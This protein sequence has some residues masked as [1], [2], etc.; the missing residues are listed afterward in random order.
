V[1]KCQS[2]LEIHGW[3]KAQRLGTLTQYRACLCF[4]AVH[5]RTV[6]LAVT[7]GKHSW[8]FA[9]GPRSYSTDYDPSLWNSFPLVT[10]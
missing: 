4:Y 5:S 6:H 8:S 10:P 7:G 2:L 9:G 1:L 3:I